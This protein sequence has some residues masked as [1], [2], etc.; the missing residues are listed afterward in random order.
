MYQ[1]EIGV[2]SFVQTG[3]QHVWTVASS[4][5]QEQ[6]SADSAWLESEPHICGIDQFTT[7]S[8]GSS[9]PSLVHNVHCLGCLRN[10]SQVGILPDDTWVMD[11][12]SSIL[13]QEQYTPL[14]TSVNIAHVKTFPGSWESKRAS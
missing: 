2:G 11:R 5:L 14:R 1:A 3:Y 13:R 9:R 12:T 8:Q 6:E 10:E 7:F 4:P